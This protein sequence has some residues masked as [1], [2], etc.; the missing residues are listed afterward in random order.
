MAQ[1]VQ[2]ESTPRPPGC[3]KLKGGEGWRIRIGDYRIIY[4]INDNTEKIYIAAHSTSPRDLQVN[5]TGRSGGKSGRR[6]SRSEW[7]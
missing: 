3:K 5:R 4:D 6:Q 1:L 2:L 7:T